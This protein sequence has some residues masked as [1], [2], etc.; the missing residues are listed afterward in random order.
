MEQI[1]QQIPFTQILF[2]HGKRGT[3]QKDEA[4]ILED[5]SMMGLTH[6]LDT[7]GDHNNNNNN[8]KCRT[9]HYNSQ[10]LRGGFDAV[11]AVVLVSRLDLAFWHE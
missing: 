9:K 2:Q 3:L 11:C 7:K 5:Q 6:K 10:R 8:N 1:S 4:T